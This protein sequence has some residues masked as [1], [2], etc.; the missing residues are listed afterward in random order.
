VQPLGAC[1]LRELSVDRV[2]AWSAANE[3]NLAPT[4]AKLAL[5]ALNQICAFAVRRGWLAGN[6]VG[7]LERGE[8]P[9]WTPVPIS[10]LEGDELAQVLAATAVHWRPVFE[11]LAYTGLRIGEA[12][13]LCW[14]DVDYEQQLVRVHRQLGRQ[15]LHAP[16]KT[17]AGRREVVLA[18]AIA[19]LLREQ[20]LAGRH[21]RPEHL[22]FCT[23]DGRG[24]DYRDAGE[25]FRA[26]VKAAGVTAPGRLSLH[27]FRHGFASLLIRRGLNVVYVSRQ[28]GHA[29]PTV[30]LS[31][32]AHCSSEP[33]M[34]PPRGKRSKAA[35]PGCSLQAR[36][37]P[38]AK[39]RERAPHGALSIPGSVGWERLTGRGPSSRHRTRCWQQPGRRSPVQRSGRSSRQPHPRCCRL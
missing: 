27:S 13:G 17:P 11:L 25:A 28:L 9:R 3:R 32:Y 18:P 37:Q 31:T 20:W 12:L 36:R 8:K 16:L 15:R 14:A 24:L 39:E 5:I 2:A 1:K 6:P 26:A 23:R 38:R 21:K 10:I 35:T 4:S 7:K 29:N 30:T 19:K 34:P 33:T 22:V